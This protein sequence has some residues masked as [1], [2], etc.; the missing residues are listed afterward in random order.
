MILRRTNKLNRIFDVFLIYR[1][2]M[3]LAKMSAMSRALRRSSGAITP[4]RQHANLYG[5]ACSTVARGTL[6]TTLLRCGC[7]SA[8]NASHLR[9][10]SAS[11]ASTASVLDTAHPRNNIPASIKARVG[12]GLLSVPGHPLSQIRDKIQQHFESGQASVGRKFKVF[13]KLSP[14]VTTTQNFDDLLTPQDHVSRSPTDTF[15]VDDSRLLRCHMTAYQTTLL[16]EGNSAFLMMGDVFRRDAVDATHY[17]VFHQIDGVRVF[18]DAELP[19]IARGGA[20]A[21]LDGEARKAAVDFVMADLKAS[22]EGMARTLFGETKMRW[23]DAYFP[24]TEPSLELEIWFE[25]QWLE[26]LGCGM[27]RQQI[28]GNCGLEERVGW[29]FGMGV[30]RLAMAM[31]GIPDIRLFWSE[32]R[33][34]LDQ[35]KKGGKVKFQPFSKYPACYKDVAFWLPTPSTVQQGQAAAGAGAPATAPTS[36]SGSS[37]IAAVAGVSFHENDFFAL[38]REVAGDLCE[39]V[40]LVDSFTHPKT[41]RSSQCYRILYRSMDRTVTNEEVDKLQDEVRDKIK[42]QLGLQLR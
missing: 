21:R 3:Q 13:D 20:G 12:K 27:I 31:Y 2:M 39:D 24:F 4:T 26:V 32:D 1:P 35:F 9:H 34:F 25:G 14:V 16:R 5:A 19:P 28:L 23:I 8:T 41:G 29:A 10:M 17:P 6:A 33:R 37:N 18:D 40:K 36:S 11:V 7:A 38:V 22:L 15:Y 42:S 30:E